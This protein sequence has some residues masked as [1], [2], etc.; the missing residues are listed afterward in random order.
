MRKIIT[1]FI[2]VLSSLIS[3]SQNISHIQQTS[4]WYYVYDT[5]NKKLATITKS[6]GELVGYSSEI[7]ILK[8][9]TWYYI[10]NATGKRLTTI[11]SSRVG[12]IIS[13]TRDQFVSTKGNWIYI[14]N[15]RGRRINTCL[16]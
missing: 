9:G 6:T 2:I 16:R 15:S 1:I 8:K 13:V 10:Y 5:N 4:S 7:F 12:E 11:E 3:Y 14:W